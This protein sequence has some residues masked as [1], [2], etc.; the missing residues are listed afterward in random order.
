MT[1][2]QSF[3][4][5]C[6]RKG[7]DSIIVQSLIVLYIFLMVIMALLPLFMTFVFSLKTTQEFHGD[8]FWTFPKTPMFSNY[9]SAFFQALPNMLNSIVISLIITFA[10]VVLAV[11]TSYVFARIKFPG[12]NVLFA[13][14]MSLMMVPMVL[15]MTPTYLTII[16]LGLKNNWLGLILP[17][18]SGHQVGTL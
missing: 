11:A 17:A 8:E 14:L 13:L 10:A 6:K 2:A 1:L 12:T 18:I 16:N 9:S 15:T 7:S 5:A 4:K 3:K